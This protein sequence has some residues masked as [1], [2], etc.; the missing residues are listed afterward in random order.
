MFKQILDVTTILRC[1]LPRHYLWPISAETQQHNQS[2]LCDVYNTWN[3]Y[4][5]DGV[6]DQ[7]VTTDIHDRLHGSIEFTLLAEFC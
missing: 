7:K 2:C 4:M 1:N 3:E 6:P 5:F